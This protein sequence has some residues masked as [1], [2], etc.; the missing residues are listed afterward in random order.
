MGKSSNSL[1]SGSETSLYSD[2]LLD[3]ILT[4]KNK[5]KG[6]KKRKADEA[7]E[8]EVTSANSDKEAKKRPK[9]PRKKRLTLVEAAAQEDKD[10]RG[11]VNFAVAHMLSIMAG[12]QDALLQRLENDPELSAVKDKLALHRKTLKQTYDDMFEEVAPAPAT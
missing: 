8:N 2:S 12:V 3:D 9:K 5:K 11:K 6:D 4:P 10:V 7:K 1:S